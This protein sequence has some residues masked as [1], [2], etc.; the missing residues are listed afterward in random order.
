MAIENIEIL[1]L[2]GFSINQILQIAKPSGVPGSGLTIL[3][4]PNNAGK[5]TVIEAIRAFSQK[6]PPS[7]TIG[8][9]NDNSDSR[10][11]LKLTNT[12]SEVKKVC[13][14]KAGGSETEWVNEDIEPLYSQL[15]VLPSRR[16]FNPFFGKNTYTREQYSSRTKIPAVRGESIDHFAF[17]LFQI[18]KNRSEFDKVLERVLSPLPNWTI[19]QADNGQYYLKFEAIKGSHSSDGIGEGIVSLFFIIDALYDSIPGDVIAI[20]EPELSLHPTLQKKLF[21]LFSDYSTDRQIIVATHSPYFVDLNVIANGAKISRVHTRNLACRISSLSDN[22]AG[23]IDGLLKNLNNPHIFGLNARELFFMHDK[24][25]MLE[26]QEDVIF[27]QKI[28]SEINVP[29]EGNVYGW[30]VGGAD[31]M[32]IIAGVVD[33]LGFEKVVGVL[34]DDKKH[35]IESLSSKYP[36]YKFF[37]IPVNDV[38]TKKARPAKEE[39]VGLIDGNGVLREQYKK[40]VEELFN[41]INDFLS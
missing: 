18:Q 14:L 25:I 23:K 5:S 1:G 3:V 15:F 24:I 40:S 9:R 38:R 30:G 16:Y 26:G 31:N 20:D 39:V 33:D 2:R 4:G 13:T 36:K 22:S 32:D 19:D 34:D 28:S 29:L 7:F 10:I 41:S 37:C 27:Y 12:K 6:E 11:C 8:K 21:S 17:R 35:Y